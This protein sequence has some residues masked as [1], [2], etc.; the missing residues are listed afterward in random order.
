[1]GDFYTDL[2]NKVD[3]P[4][5]ELETHNQDEVGKVVAAF[6]ELD[7]GKRF[8]ELLYIE[9]VENPRME[10]IT[11]LDSN[12]ERVEPRIDQ[13]ELAYD[14]GKSDVYY[15][16]KLSGELYKERT[17]NLGEQAYE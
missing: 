5:Q 4:I 3:N 12:L 2:M 8:M 10:R 16:I 1:M 14:M 17:K 13:G 11:G 9:L 6:L 7:I 15:K